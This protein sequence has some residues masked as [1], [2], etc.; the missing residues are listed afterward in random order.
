MYVDYKDVEL[1]K[2]QTNRHSKIV[3]R[4]KSGCH[5]ISQQLVGLSKPYS[6]ADA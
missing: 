2:Q 1:L 3:G 6:V 5:A 4:R